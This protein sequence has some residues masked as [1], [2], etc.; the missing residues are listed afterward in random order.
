MADGRPPRR[1][2][3]LKSLPRARHTDRNR[4]GGPRP[5]WSSPWRLLGLLRAGLLRSLSGSAPQRA[6]ELAALAARGPLPDP[7]PPTGS[8]RL[9]LL[10]VVAA[11]GTVIASSSELRGVPA[12]LAPDA[13]A[14]EIIDHH[15]LPDHGPWLTEPTPATI[16]NR[17]VTVIVFTSLEEFSRSE[18]I[19]GGLLAAAVPILSGLVGLLVWFVVGRSL[20]AVEVMRTDVANITAMQLD[21]RVVIPAADDELAKLARTLND[22]LDRLEESHR[23]QHRFVADASHELRT[24]IANIRTALEVAAA[25]PARAD[26]A[27]IADDVLRQDLRMQRLADDLLALARA[28]LD[29]TVTTFA[30]V[31]LCDLVHEE[32]SRRIP[33]SRTLAVVPGPVAVIVNGDREQLRRAVAN[34]IDNALRHANR[35]VTV[36][37]S[38]GAAWAQVTVSDDGAGVPIDARDQV[39]DRFVR[40]DTDRANAGQGAGLGLSIVREIVTAHGGTVS[41]LDGPPPG[42]RFAMR[43]PLA[44]RLSDLS[45]VVS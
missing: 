1:S 16:A 21:R 5:C 44:P 39:F 33:S 8:P 19:L 24:P 41:I 18:Q 17:P 31:D 11:N 25:H 6:A 36:A 9:T 40:L 22:M 34:L 12:I 23:R 10:Q 42:A 29:S 30:A 20:R 38:I 13:R 14:R 43:L 35:H 2:R 26:W 15:G 3:K 37:L 32:T 7:L 45:G 28:D 4:R 27:S